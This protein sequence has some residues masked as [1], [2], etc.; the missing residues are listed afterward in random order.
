MVLTVMTARPRGPLSGDTIAGKATS[1]V[2][3]PHSGYHF[4]GRKSRFFEGWYF[5]VT[6]PRSGDAFALIYAIED[7]GGGAFPGTSAQIMGPRDSYLLQFSKDTNI[8]WGNTSDLELGCTF[9]ARNP[10]KEG[11]PIGRMLPEEE[12]SEQVEQGFQASGTWHQ[13]SITAQG[14]G[15]GGYLPSTVGSARWA[16]SVSPLLGWGPEGSKQRSTAGW[17]AALPVFE[18]HWQVMMAKGRATGWLEWGEQRLDFQDAPIYAEKNWG[19][20]FPKK[21]F[22]IQC[23]DFQDSPSTALTSV[24]AT[25]GLLG[26]AGLEE[27]VGMIG[28]HHQGTFHELVPWTGQVEWE[29]EPWGSWRV[30][31]RNNE[32]KALVEATCPAAGTALRAPTATNGLFPFCRDSFFGQ[33]RVRLWKVEG[34][35]RG[36]GLLLADVFSS[37]AALEVGGGPWWSTWRARADM[38]EPLRSLVAAPVD[39]EQLLSRLPGSWRPPG[40]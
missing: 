3:T 40:L 28:F 8:F 11:Q 10:L 25:R 33:V 31:A 23:E 12:F 5:K 37:R 21:W 18:P 30:W 19:G 14:E 34:Q 27:D 16:F 4:D 29:V 9:K 24:G 2:R 7:P 13:G 36:E 35:G 17:L 1:S 26:V 20:G 38:K 15:A 32:Y 39:P 6:L 22:W